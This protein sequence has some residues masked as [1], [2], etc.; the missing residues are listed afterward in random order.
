MGVLCKRKREMNLTFISL[1]PK[2]EKKTLDPSLRFPLLF[3]S[4]PPPTLLSLSL[5]QGGRRP[6]HGQARPGAPSA[7]P[8]A[9]RAGQAA[10]RAAAAGQGGRGGGGSRLGRRGSRLERSEGRNS[11]EW[12]F[13]LLSF[14]KI[15]FFGETLTL[16]L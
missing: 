9:A 12:V 4:P 6:G 14:L 11:C 13:P 1:N 15:H 7:R 8:G 3:L 10:A 16:D 5:S 2:K